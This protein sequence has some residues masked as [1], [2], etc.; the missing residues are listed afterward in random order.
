MEKGGVR[1]RG[2]ALGPPPEKEKK[3]R[4]REG[5]KKKERTRYSCSFLAARSNGWTRKARRGA[6]SV[7]SRSF[8]FVRPGRIFAWM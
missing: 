2:L 5:R 8:R 3:E 7:L 6:D 4:E 1:G